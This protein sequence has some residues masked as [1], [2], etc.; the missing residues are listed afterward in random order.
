MKNILV[1]VFF[2][3]LL[4]GCAIGNAP[5][6]KRMDQQVG[7]KVSFLDPTRFGNAGDLIRAD[8]LVQ[9][10]GF[11]HITKNKDGDIIQHW[12]SSEVLPAHGDKKWVGK[13]KYYYVVNPETNII[14]GWGYDEGSNPE[15][16]RDWL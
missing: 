16:C 10:Q 3:I 4:N 1:I 2:A 13:C 9:G 11:T 5:F 7:A 15:S 8:Y 14:K 12:F 6:A